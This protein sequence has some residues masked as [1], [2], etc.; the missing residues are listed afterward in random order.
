MATFKLH[1]LA[2]SFHKFKQTYFILNFNIIL[3]VGVTKTTTSKKGKTDY[4]RIRLPTTRTV[5][6]ADAN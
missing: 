4:V 3:E 2:N 5:A 1:A 6:E